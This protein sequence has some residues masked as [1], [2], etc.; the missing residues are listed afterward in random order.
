MAQLRVHVHDMDCAEEAALVRR[1]L[2][3]NRAIQRVEFDL[4]H[5]FVDITFDE[6]AT[7]E[8]ALIEAVRSVGLG[9]HGVHG[10]DGQRTVAD[11]HAAHRHHP[12]GTTIAIAISGLLFAAGWIVEGLHAEDWLDTFVHADHAGYEARAAVAYGL[13]ALA[14]LWPMWRRAAAAIRYLRL[15]MHALVCLTVIGAALLGQWSE[16]AAVAFLFGL[17]HRMETWSI[18]RARREIAALVGRG[19]ALVAHGPHQHAVATP[20]LKAVEGWGV[21]GG[22]TERWIE[23]FAAIYTP[24]VVG[25]S[26][27]VAIVP[28]LIDGSWSTWFYRALLFLVL[29]CPCALVISTP[30]TMVAALSAAARRGVLVKGGAVLERAAKASSS[31][32]QGLAAAGVIVAGAQAYAEL[33]RADVVVADVDER[34]MALL[35]ESARRAMRVLRQNV[36]IALLTKLAFLI[37]APFAFAPLWMAVLADTGATVVVTLNG[38]R[39]LSARQDPAA[40]IPPESGGRTK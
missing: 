35:V 9:A 16:G 11:E 34:A 15:D 17:A 4:I 23:R 2:G 37:S 14:G 27:A 32:R 6:R 26:V 3:S 36:A 29:A 31:T 24:I 22:E 12:H 21:S 30:V 40:R 25:L 19:P 13:S 18:E 1:A 20:D 38:L 10:E 39:L 8:A 7:S 33:D 28:P 5:G